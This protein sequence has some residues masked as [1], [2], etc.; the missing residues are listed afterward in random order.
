MD[1]QP[2]EIAYAGSAPGMVEGMVQVNARIPASVTPGPYVR[3]VLEAG[4]FIS[5]STIT[6]S[7]RSEP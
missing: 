2:A 1:G 7:V 4:D 3:V 5:P 6:L